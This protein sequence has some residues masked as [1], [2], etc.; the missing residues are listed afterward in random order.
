MI[1]V[2][3][4]LCDH[5]DHGGSCIV[6]RLCV[7]DRGVSI[8]NEVDVR[9]SAISDHGDHAM[10]HPSAIRTPYT[11]TSGTA[12]HPRLSRLSRGIGLAPYDS[13][14][15]TGL[16]AIIVC[17]ALVFELYYGIRFPFLKRSKSVE[18][19]GAGPPPPR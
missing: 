18:L 10:P 1:V 16:L 3:R 4:R 6:V 7:L 12:Q 5:G 9:P 17:L 15:W 14:V 13:Q 19:A 11:S 8:L 2:E